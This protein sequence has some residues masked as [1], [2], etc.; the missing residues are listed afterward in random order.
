MHTFPP[1][2]PPTWQCAETAP[3]L[4]STA[5]PPLRPGG[6]P[7]GE[8][9]AGPACICA[10]MRVRVYVWVR[11][12]LCAARSH[13][14]TLHNVVRSTA[15]CPPHTHPTHISSAHCPTHLQTEQGGLQRKRWAPLVLEHIKADRAIGAADVGVPHLHVAP[16]QPCC[17][18]AQSQLSALQ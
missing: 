13:T 12:C 1:P 11:V 17:I 16:M 10:C 8:R 2:P 14:R 18:G 3:C 4:S 5:G 7:A 6:H 9:R 15:N